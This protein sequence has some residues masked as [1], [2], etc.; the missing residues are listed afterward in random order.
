MELQIAIQIPFLW[1]SQTFQKTEWGFVN[2]LV[3]PNG[4]GK[5]LFAE[6]L[7]DQCRKQE[8]TPRYLNAE[9]LVGLERQSYGLF[10]SGQMARG[11]NVDQFSEYRSRGTAYGL[12]TDAFVILKEKLDVRIRIEATLSQLFGRGI[13]LVEQGGFLK[14]MLQKIRNGDPYDLRENECHGLKELI[15]LLTFLYD[16][17]NNCLIIDEPEL[18]LHPQFQTLVLQE[19]RAIAGDPR[20]DPGKKCFFLITHSPY[21]VDIRTLDD[22]RNCIVFQPSN[23]PIFISQLDEEDERRIK[24]L[25]PRL[26]TH[27]KQFFFASRPIFVEGY[28]DQQLFAL[29]QE[30]RG[31]L[32]G[33]SGAGLIDVGGKEELDLFFRLCTVLNIDAQI[34]ADLDVLLHGKLRQSVAQD[35]RCMDYFQKEGLGVDAM[36]VL[37]PMEKTIDQCSQEL[38][39]ALTNGTASHSELEPLRD[40]L[41]RIDGIE[42][43]QKRTTKRRYAFLVGL[44]N[45]CQHIA[46]L[47][48]ESAGNLDFI[49]GRLQKTLEAFR[50]SG[51]YILDRGELENYLPEYHGNP[52]DVPDSKKQKVFERELDFLLRED[53]TE[54]D[55]STR[56]SELVEILDEVS[57]STAID[58][59][60]NL[61]YVIG[62]WIHRV[63]SA[64][65]R[66]EVTDRE[67]LIRN[68]AVEWDSHSRIL[69]LLSFT[70]NCEGFNCRIKL[71]PLID[72][73]EREIEFDK[74]IVPANYKLPKA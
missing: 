44:R 40:A 73:S 11:F 19:I 17:E 26:N 23:L 55:I 42:D 74:E 9:R 51:V 16:D 1:D 50:Q 62:D 57:R 63:Q 32:L 41:S 69:E 25:L 6:Q 8:L 66:G 35:S 72:P 65:A 47:L 36:V 68:L 37:G 7:Q 21:Y 10:G 39:T 48:P 54:Q 29:I 38:E 15:A 70:K 43:Q 58:L 67:S 52:Y 27:H 71:K 34:I 60:Q 31:K 45:V 2:F 18:H 64:V 30:K 33:A 5:T 46:E 24:R 13:Q 20:T 59:D 12:S 56:Y 22:L 49:Q 28:F 14:P 61:S 4:T 53:M 3:G